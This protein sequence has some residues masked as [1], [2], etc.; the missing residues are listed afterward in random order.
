MQQQIHRHSGFSY[1]I[2]KN[3]PFQPA[4]QLWLILQ[5]ASPFQQAVP[6]ASYRANP[7]MKKTNNVN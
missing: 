6:S 7:V 2:Q 3:T 5:L 4:Q 1:K